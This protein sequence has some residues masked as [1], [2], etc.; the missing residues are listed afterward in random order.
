MRFPTFQTTD[1]ALSMKFRRFLLHM[2]LCYDVG[3]LGNLQVL[4]RPA[5]AVGV[6]HFLFIFDGFAGFAFNQQDPS[7]IFTILV[8]ILI[9]SLAFPLR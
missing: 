1:L 3:L 2:H 4:L 6:F 7:Q 9:C 5:N 8:E